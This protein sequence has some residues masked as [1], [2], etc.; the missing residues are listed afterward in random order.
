MN[1]DGQQPHI[2]CIDHTP[3]ILSLLRDLLGDEGFR[4]TT[5]THTHKDL[6]Q[7]VALA[8]DVITLD[9]MWTSADDD[10]AYLQLLRLDR[11]TAHIPIVLCTGAVREVVGLGEQLRRMLVTVVLKPFDIAQ[12]V[13]AVQWALGRPA[14]AAEA[15]DVDANA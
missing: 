14:P 15:A 1:S 8:P 9:Y 6:D 3:E 13:H 11:R 2:L 12:L 4:V 5:L 10:W 7:I